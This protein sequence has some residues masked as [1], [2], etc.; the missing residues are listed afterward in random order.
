MAVWANQNVNL[1][2][3]NV[4]LEAAE[5][6]GGKQSFGLRIGNAS[7]NT[8]NPSVT[9]KGE[10]TEIAGATAGISVIGN[11]ASAVSSL[12]LE[13]GT[14]YGSDFG[15]VG[16]GDCDGTSIEIK[17]GTV[18]STS[19]DGCAI[20][21]PQDG[22]LT[23]SGG[24]LEGANGV[25]FCGE[26][27]LSIEGGSINATAAEIASSDTTTTSSS[28]LDGAALS[29]VSRGGGGVRCRGHCRGVHHRRHAD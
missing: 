26:G 16:N 18:R 24:T 3:D 7:G 4:I 15:I 1:T 8:S 25:Q 14:V 29:L 27:K 11:G 13:A 21:H 9:I 23:V 10:D 17:G 28:I 2:L 5:A 20:Y 22:G 19:E 12:T 6:P